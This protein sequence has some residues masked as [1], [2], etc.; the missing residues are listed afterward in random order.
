MLAR[1]EGLPIPLAFIKSLN[2]S[3]STCFPAVSI[4]RNSV[5]SVYC[6]GGMFLF[7]AQGKML[8]TFP[9]LKLG[10][11]FSSFLSSFPVDLVFSKTTLQPGF[12]ISLPLALN[13]SSADSPLPLYLK[14][15]SLDKKQ[16]CSDAPPHHKLFAHSLTNALPDLWVQ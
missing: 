14:Q 2:S 1:V 9:L 10:R 5:A 13:F 12:N 8:I 7:H 3:S 4:A 16:R 6:F 11:I 15:Y